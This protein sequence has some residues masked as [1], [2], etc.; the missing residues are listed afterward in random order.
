MI[1]HVR[2]AWS[3]AHSGQLD[4]T[5]PSLWNAGLRNRIRRNV[6]IQLPF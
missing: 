3:I 4:L 1:S 5:A 2:M 6:R